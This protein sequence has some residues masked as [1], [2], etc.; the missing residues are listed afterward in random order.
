MDIDKVLERLRIQELNTMQQTACKTILGTADDVV[1]LSPTGSGKTLA[2]LLPTAHLVEENSEQVQ[3]LVVVPG[4]ELALQSSNVLK[5]MA[6]GVRSVSCYGGRPAM[7]EHRTLK[8]VK[9]QVVFGTPG[10]LNDHW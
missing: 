10:R 3:V 1:L 4:R 9:P 6:C 2:Y 8:Q 7:E 5:M